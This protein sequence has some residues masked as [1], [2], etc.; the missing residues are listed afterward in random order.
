MVRTEI[1][2]IL[3]EISTVS[4]TVGEDNLLTEETDTGYTGCGY[5][6]DHT[7]CC[8]NDLQVQIAYRVIGMN[9]IKGCSDGLGVTSQ[10]LISV[11]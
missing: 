1:S 9:D 10:K 4:A 3:T 7:N 11:Q 8:D 6:I 5:C 2:K